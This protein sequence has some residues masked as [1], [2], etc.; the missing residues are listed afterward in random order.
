MSQSVYYIPSDL[1][2][3]GAQEM[4]DVPLDDYTDQ[5]LFLPQNG[6]AIPIQNPEVFEK[7]VGKRYLLQAS[8]SQLLSQKNT[9]DEESFSYLQEKYMEQV[10]IVCYVS[11]L[12]YDHVKEHFPNEKLVL[13]NTFFIQQNALLE[14]RNDLVKTLQIANNQPYTLED[15]KNLSLLQSPTIK[16]L[17]SQSTGLQSDGLLVQPTDGVVLIS[18]EEARHF[19]LENVFSIPLEEIL[20]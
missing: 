6:K 4:I 7:I 16:E 12:L 17:I 2:I 15:L 5:L 19:L 14:H 18:D 20:K 11:K 9:L 13:Y 3:D 8:V 10:N 1:V